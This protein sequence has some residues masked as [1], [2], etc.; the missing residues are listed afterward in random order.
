MKL[1]R[2]VRLLAPLAV[3]LLGILPVARAQLIPVSVAGTGTYTNSASLIIDGV[4]PPEMTRADDSSVVWWT[5][6]ATPVRFTIDFGAAYSL[7]SFL[8]SVDNNDTYSFEYS[9][10]G[11]TYSSL[12]VVNPLAGE[13]TFGMESLATAMAH[14]EFESTISTG[15][16]SARY[17]RTSVWGG[18]NFYAI[19]EIEAWGEPLSPGPGP[20]PSSVPEPSTYGVIGA[21]LLLG[22]IT[23]ASRSGRRI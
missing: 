17:V 15:P 21:A 5:A 23:L 13:T 12:F 22:L 16:V 14:V 8:V 9:L 10:D 1:P 7:T 4:L 2:S 11:S 18:D 19:G 6:S 20:L 3:F